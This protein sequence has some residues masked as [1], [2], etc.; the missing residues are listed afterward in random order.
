MSTV[1]PKLKVINGIVYAN[2]LK[3]AEDFGKQHQVVMRLIRSQI[4]AVSLCNFAQRDPFL[5]LGFI[6]TNY[7]NS[8]SQ[9]FPCYLLNRE[10]FEF[11]ALGLTGVK[12]VEWKLNYIFA[13]RRIQRE[14][15][16]TKQ[17]IAELTQ[18][19]LF[20]EDVRER[21]Y[22]IAEVLEKLAKIGLFN[23]RTTANAIKTKIKRGEIVGRFDGTRYVMPESSLRSFIKRKEFTV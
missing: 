5:K 8:R 23:S 13:F 7:K 9:E 3:V 2:S 10:A 17:K 16:Q 18:L 12:A 22:T 14:L 4:N 11:V 20:P 15:Q 6:L 19:G 21:E 1:S